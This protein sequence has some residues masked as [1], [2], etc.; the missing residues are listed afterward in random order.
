MNSLIQYS[1]DGECYLAFK[2]II[3]SSNYTCMAYVPSWTTSCG[4]ILLDSWVT[5][6]VRDVEGRT[7]AEVA[8][9]YPEFFI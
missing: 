4:K 6:L 9:K 1:I 5:V 7:M 3:P 2:N 8:D